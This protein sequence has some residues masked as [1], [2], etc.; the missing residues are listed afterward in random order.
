[1]VATENNPRRPVAGITFPHKRCRWRVKEDTHS[2]HSGSLDDHEI[3]Y[4]VPQPAAPP[5]SVTGTARRRLLHAL[6]PV[7]QRKK[8]S[9]GHSNT[10]FSKCVKLE[11]TI[12][13]SFAKL[14]RIWGSNFAG[15]E[16]TNM[17]VTWRR[18]RG[19]YRRGG[20]SPPWGVRRPLGGGPPP[21][22]GGN[23][24]F[25]P[26]MVVTPSPTWGNP[27]FNFAWHSC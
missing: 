14:R 19:F 25:I 17:C 16:R 12:W 3:V 1:M 21:H 18:G 27:H 15:E 11:L 26:F 22:H 4:T 20:G 9:V 8:G 5:C 2:R 13:Q 6:G 24:L 7:G 23:P 10:H